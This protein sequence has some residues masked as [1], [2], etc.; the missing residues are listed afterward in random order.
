MDRLLK[1]EGIPLLL[2]NEAVVRGAVEAGIGACSTYPGTPASEIG[3]T[4]ARIADEAGVQFE[5]SVN[6]IVAM[7]TA[8]AFSLSGWRSMAV[9][10]HVGLNVAADAFMTF[11]YLGTAGGAVIVS[12]DD[13]G[14]HSSQNEQDN[15]HFARMAGVPMLEPATPEEA[16]VLTRRAF[17]LSET[18]G[19][20]FMLRLT[21]RIAHMRG[22]VNLGPIPANPV[23]GRVFERDPGNRVVVPAVARPRH[24]RLKE[25]LATAAE[26]AERPEFFTLTKGNGDLG[27]IA[28]GVSRTLAGTAIRELDLDGR[29][30]LLELAFTYPFPEGII[31]EFLCSND[32]ILVLEELT[33]F[34]EEAIVAVAHRSGANVE[35]FGKRSGHTSELGES[36]PDRVMDAVADLTGMAD[37]V[38]CPG[39]TAEP[40]PSRPPTLCPGCPHRASYLMARQVVGRDTLV[41]SDIGCYTL[42]MSP[43]LEMADLLVCMGASVST[44]AAL[45]AAQ[46]RPVLAVIGDSTFLHGGIPG[47][48]NAVS[49]NRKMLVLILDNR[50]T[51]MTGF[52]PHPGARGVGGDD[53]V[54]SFEALARACGAGLVK[55]A[56]PYRPREM[57]DA[58]EGAWASDGVSVVISRSP[59]PQMA[60]RAGTMPTRPP[61][62]ILRHRCRTCGNAVSGRHCGMKTDEGYEEIRVHKRL[63]WPQ[64]LPIP[65]DDPPCTA[66]CPAQLCV[67][68][69]VGLLAAGEFEKAYEHVRRRIPLPAACAYVCHRPCEEACSETVEGDSVAIRH[70]KKMAV[71]YG[72]RA[73]ITEPGEATGHKVAVV[74]AG[75]AG[76]SV[77]GDLRERGHEVALFDSADEPGGLLL[78]AIPDFRLPRDVVRREIADI[79]D[80]GVDFSGGF[81]LGR[82]DT[83]DGF[84]SGDFDAVVL[85]IGLSQRVNI[86]IPGDDLEG[87]E[88]ALDYLKRSSAGEQLPGGRNVVVIGGG[89]TAFDAAR[90]ALR[91]GAM[92]VDLVYRRTVEEMPALREEIV[93]A[94]RDGVR[95]SYLAAPIGFEGEGGRVRSGTYLKMQLGDPDESGRRRPVPQEGSEFE[96]ESDLV[97]L[98]LGQMA[99]PSSTLGLGDFMGPDGG[100]PPVDRETMMTQRQGVFVCGDAT[101]GP[102]TVIDAI[103]QGKAAAT[104]VDVFLQTGRPGVAQSSIPPEDPDPREYSRAGSLLGV[105]AGAHDDMAW[106]GRDVI[107]GL[108]DEQTVSMAMAEANRCLQC[109]TCSNCNACIDLTGCPA[110]KSGPDGPEVIRS[111]CNGCG[112]CL[113]VCPNGAIVAD[114]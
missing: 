97:L 55:T 18:I 84:L 72:Y 101:G 4:F 30:S 25:M 62:R 79:M 48:I 12:A 44:G 59:C 8:I 9:M 53:Q 45:S 99:A 65:M 67:Q 113:A 87:V 22:P 102:A 50:T 39:N 51:A 21:T 24:A 75:P 104:S 85:A 63:K 61:V 107:E 13:P 19:L 10:K 6:E 114:E 95:I 66:A 7:E 16:R 93:H 78:S 103:A 43:P 100:F 74:G 3:D 28:S 111:L 92:S 27:I 5:Y 40:L 33:P 41:A 90:T 76:L 86:A 49:N 91:A 34:L 47:L 57:L 56:D 31:A 46:D 37:R 109:G 20:P 52:Q 108:S 17:E 88:D 68:G 11:P 1:T 110:L 64:G 15:R 89:N 32:R 71:K 96:I 73:G 58:L 2:G 29:V 82:D 77:A 69:Y 14:C 42:G 70:L 106:E 80:M 81:V 94:E 23:A 98:A 36:N 26:A 105:G 35:V 83:P 60:D 38:Q 54:V 112:L